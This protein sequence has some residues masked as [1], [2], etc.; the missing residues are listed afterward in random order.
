MKSPNHSRRLFPSITQRPQG[1][2]LALVILAPALTFTF[3]GRAAEPFPFPPEVMH[4]DWMDARRQLQL[5]SSSRFDVFHEFQFTDTL[6]ESGITFE[7]KVVDDAGKHHKP[8]HYDHGNG[9]AVADV[10]GDGLL[11]VYFSTQLGSNALWR[12]LGK[13]KFTEMTTPAIALKDKIGVT[14]SFADTDNDGDPDLFVTTVRDGNHFFV[15][16]GKGRFTDQSAASG[17]DHRGHSS[18]GVF[19]DYDKDGLLDLFLCNVGLY[20]QAD[21]RGR[22]G[23]YVGVSD[24]FAGHLKPGERN[25]R[26][27]LYHNEGNNR[28]AEVSAQLG[29]DDVSWTGDASPIDVNEDG[30]PDLYVLNMQGHDEYYENVQGK[31]FQRRSREIF[32]KTSWGAMGIKVFDY[33]NDARMDLFITDMHS[34]MSQRQGPNQEKLKS[35]MLWPESMLLSEGKSIYGNTFFRNLGGGRYAEVSDKIG[36]EN[37]WPWGL[38]VGDLNADGW[39]DVFITASMNFPFRYGVNSVLVNNRGKEFLNSE[40]ILGVEPRRDGRTAKPWFRLDPQ[41]EDKEHPLVKDHRLTTPVDVWAAL[42]SR[43]S[44]IFDL[45][46]DGD[47]DILTNEFNDVPMVL[48]SDLASKKAIRFLKIKLQGTQ[49]NRDGLGAVVKVTTT[50]GAYTKVNDGV[51]GYLSHSLLP[52]Y[53]GLGDDDVRVTGITVAWPSGVRQ[54]Q[55]NPKAISGEVIVITEPAKK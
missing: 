22:G 26:S 31:R 32:P 10:D 34:D 38:S 6:V 52:L 2:F 45:D 44:A 21:K 33:D 15:N 17:L 27:L 1:A 49:S 4:P 5:A 19:F 24:A 20:S 30:W 18:S 46:N 13:G 7:N 9:I 8:V 48:T 39:E 43:S 16:D 23:Y 47:L 11:D 36:A 54:E 51:S 28:F 41:G 14:A 42:G 50:S 25:E 3:F 29:L 35:E 53:F 37:Y 55:N 40:F 12:N